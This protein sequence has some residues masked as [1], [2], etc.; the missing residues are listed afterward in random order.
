M[1]RYVIEVRIAVA[2]SSD[3]EQLVRF[4]VRPEEE[5]AFHSTVR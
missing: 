2:G 4:L 3:F 5:D 1:F